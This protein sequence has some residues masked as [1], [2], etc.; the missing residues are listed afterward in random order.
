MEEITRGVFA[1]YEVM[2]FLLMFFLG[3]LWSKE[4]ATP[5][6]YGLLQHNLVSSQTL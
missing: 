3:M 4:N 5:K 2:T 6:M 1:A